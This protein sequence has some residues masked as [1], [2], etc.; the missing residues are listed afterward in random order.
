MSG[1]PHGGLTALRIWVAALLLLVIN[2]HL[3]KG[4]GLAPGWLTGKLSDVAGLLAAPPLLA[5][6]LSRLGLERRRA[7]VLACFAVGC[8]FA[9]LQVSPRCAA[10]FDA[11]LTDAAHAL[12][13]PLR[14]RTVSDP[15]DL[16]ALAVLPLAFH[17]AVLL[18]IQRG[19]PARLLLVFA[20]MACCATSVS[21]VQVMPH[22]GLAGADEGARA[23]KGFRGGALDLRMGKVSAEGSFELGIVLHARDQPVVMDLLAIE[24][25]L[26]RERVTAGVGTGE[27]QWL[28]AAPGQAA[29]ARVHFLVAGRAPPEDADLDDIPQATGFLRV[30][31]DVGGRTEVARVELLY[32]ARIVRIDRMQR[33]HAGGTR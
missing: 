23:V 2:D 5:W 24:A 4:A 21:A 9:A 13:L 29:A 33:F 27:R 26:D 16:Y 22:W 14:S 18:R 30:P 17:V 7:C 32:R 12:A 19:L 28:R 15:T 31:I 20:S 6:L 3:L 11:L 8:G 25:W 1:A 10:A